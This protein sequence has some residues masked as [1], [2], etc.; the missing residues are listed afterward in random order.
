[1]ARSGRD[2]PLT[3]VFVDDD[4]D[5]IESVRIS[6][7]GEPDFELVATTTEASALLDL[8]REHQ[9]D[10]VILDH[11]LRG[12]PLLR[13]GLDRHGVSATQTGLEL[14]A[15]ARAAAPDA[16]I[17]IFTGRTGLGLS[18][19]NVGADL[20]V[21]KPASVGAVWSAIREARSKK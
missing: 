6:V 14:V 13:T 9:P 5:M 16:T 7:D 3:V 2:A 10:V 15:F 8:V 21:E 19:Q 11:Q 17:V 12:G 1:M 20:Y 18:A 4:P